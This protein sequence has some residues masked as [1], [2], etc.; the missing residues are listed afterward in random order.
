MGCYFER[1]NKLLKSLEF[2]DQALKLELDAELVEDPS[3]THLNLC[4]VLSRLKRHDVA[5]QHAHCAIDILQDHLLKL[6]SEW[7]QLNTCPPVSDPP[8]PFFSGTSPPPPTTA[9]GRIRKRNRDAPVQERMK[10]AIS[11]FATANY[12][13]ACELERLHRFADALE[14]HRKAAEGARQAFGSDHQ[15][16]VSSPSPTCAPHSSCTRMHAVRL[17]CA[18]HNVAPCVLASDILEIAGTISE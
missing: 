2:L 5:F 11:K 15:L 7:A 1:R 13:A 6:N 3:A 10:D 18:S 9:E 14:F 17:G 12:N 16:T 4:R 8:T